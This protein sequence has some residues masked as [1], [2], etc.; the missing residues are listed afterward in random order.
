MM[1]A[2]SELPEEE[3]PP[4]LTDVTG[5]DFPPTQ[6]DLVAAARGEER[7]AEAARE[8]LCRMYWGPLWSFA[9]AKGLQDA[10]AKDAVQGFLAE[11]LEERGG[12]GSAEEERGRLRSYLL[13]CFTH[14]MQGRWM[15]ERAEKRGG[16]SAPLPYVE[17]RH[18]P[19]DKESPEH[20]YDR[21]WSVM[22]LREA[23]IRLGESYGK[24][25]RGKEFHW[26]GPLLTG[27]RA[28]RGASLAAAK[29]LGVPEGT[30]AS[31][32]SRMR[33]RFRRALVETVGTTM[34]GA[35]E[36]EVLA[37]MDLLKAAVQ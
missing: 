3:D 21:S 36:A 13:A 10:D 15:R 28:E 16:G 33:K 11:F 22:I 12:F 32:L 23:M 34:G 30:M 25:G 31:L 29:A 19:W 4:S 37:E 9:R 20:L 18:A 7:T 6:W 27:G 1:R 17:E 26:L 14:H 35:S 2:A 24:E 5:E 8:R